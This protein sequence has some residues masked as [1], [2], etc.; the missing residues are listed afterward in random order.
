[1]QWSHNTVKWLWLLFAVL[2]VDN[3][4][5]QSEF[6]LA[7]DSKRLKQQTLYLNVLML[8]GFGVL[9][10][11]PEDI[12]LWTNDEK[13]SINGWAEAWKRNVEQGPVWDKDLF[14]FNWIAHPLQGADYY[15]IARKNNYSRWQSFAYSAFVSTF[16]WEFGYEAIKEVPSRQDI[17]ITPILGSVLGEYFLVQTQ[18]IQNNDYKVWGSKNWGKFLIFAMNPVGVM[19]NAMVGRNKDQLQVHSSWQSGLNHSLQY[20]LHF[21]YQF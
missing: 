14:F 20:Q 17:L 15:L 21:S 19:S 8:G 4:C 18:T 6:K 5:A 7:K 16:L 9:T 13:N 10:Q 2:I 11:L 12:T 3:V 1:M